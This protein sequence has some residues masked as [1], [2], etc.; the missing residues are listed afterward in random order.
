MVCETLPPE[1]L[2]ISL[3]MMQ[4]SPGL[5]HVPQ[6]SEEGDRGSQGGHT[7]PPG[8]KETGTEEL[9]PPIHPRGAQSSSYR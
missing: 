7:Q 5:D 6:R 4:G 2:G 3:L 9:G 1:V 8:Q